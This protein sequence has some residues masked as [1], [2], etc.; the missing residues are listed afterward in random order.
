[1]LLT[2]LE[3]ENSNLTQVKVDEV[4]GLMSHV[5]AKISSHNAVPSRIV[6]LVKFLEEN[7]LKSYNIFLNVIFFQGLCSTLHRV[8]LHLLRHIC[9]FDHSLS[10]TH[11]YLQ[12]MRNYYLIHLFYKQGIQK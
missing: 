12:R 4:F 11:D 5:A 8:L 2:R 3:K 6:F 9:I 7:P 10:I 1:I